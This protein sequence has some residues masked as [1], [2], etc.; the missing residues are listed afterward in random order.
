M[1][2]SNLVQPGFEPGSTRQESDAVATTANLSHT[3]LLENYNIWIT[4]C[5]NLQCFIH[6]KRFNRAW[7]SQPDILAGKIFPPPPIFS[8]NHTCPMLKSWY[9]SRKN[10]SGPLGVPGGAIK[11]SDPQKRK[12]HVFSHIFGEKNSF[13]F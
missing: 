6:R 8:W 4:K 3:K 12:N 9:Q 7:L 5:F 13:H 11:G 1:S 2:K 10:I